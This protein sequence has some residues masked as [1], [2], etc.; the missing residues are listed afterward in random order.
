[1]ER[2]ASFEDGLTLLLVDGADFILQQLELRAEGR[3]Y[4]L[5]A[6]LNLTVYV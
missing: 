1:M 4:V 2:E 6:R 5:G 3:Q